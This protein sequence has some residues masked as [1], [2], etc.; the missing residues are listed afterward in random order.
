LIVFNDV[1]LRRTRSLYF[2][3]YHRSRTHLSLEKDSPEP[4]SVQPT[5]LGPVVSLP[6]VSGLHYRYERR[7]A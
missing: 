7:A 1:S 5:K 3:Y 4:R 2:D 6:Q